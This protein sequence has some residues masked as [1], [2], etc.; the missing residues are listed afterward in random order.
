MIYYIITFKYEINTYNGGKLMVNRE[1]ILIKTR[2]STI[3]ECR[4]NCIDKIGKV[5]YASSL[6]KSLVG[7]ITPQDTF[8]IASNQKGVAT[9]EFVGEIYQKDNDIF[10]KGI[11]RPRKFSM[12][13]VYAY[14]VFGLIFGITLILSFNPVFMFFGLLFMLVPWLNVVHLNKSNA[15]YDRILQKVT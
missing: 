15:L 14:V 2:F 9:H 12:I 1:D 6:G 13:I 11:I 8:V 4:G 5:R 10:M 3:E 7:E